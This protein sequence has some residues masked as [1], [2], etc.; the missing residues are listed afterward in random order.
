MV[1]L[2]RKCYALI[3]T[4]IISVQIVGFCFMLIEESSMKEVPELILF[5]Y[6]VGTPIILLYGVPVSILSDKLC[7]RFEGVKRSFFS[8]II[9]FFA[10]FMFAFVLRVIESDFLI[11]NL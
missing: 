7:K 6:V 5:T 8:F 3:L 11:S 1:V 9:H 4:M 10:G 2:L